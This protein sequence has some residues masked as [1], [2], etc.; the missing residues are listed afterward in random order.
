MGGQTN[1]QNPKPAFFK[2]LSKKYHYDVFLRP[3]FPRSR[4]GVKSVP[5]STYP[6][7]RSDGE[8]DDVQQTSTSASSVQSAAA[9]DATA[10]KRASR[11]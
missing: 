10:T 4:G 3:S 1:T 7:V 5:G 11:A 2:T 8:R 9:V 6:F